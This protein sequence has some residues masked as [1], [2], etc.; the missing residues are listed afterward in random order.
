MLLLRAVDRL[1]DRAGRLELA[2]FA[3]G[4]R[5]DEIAL[6]LDFLGDGGG[7]RG[8]L[9]LATEEG[10]PEGHGGSR[11][12]FVLSVQQNSRRGAL[13]RKGLVRRGPRQTLPLARLRIADAEQAIHLM[14]E[15]LHGRTACQGP[16]AFG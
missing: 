5:A 3:I 4:R 13:S 15:S 7:G 9:R 8:G 16:S 10:F 14:A 6:V 2:G 11:A 1:L 12:G